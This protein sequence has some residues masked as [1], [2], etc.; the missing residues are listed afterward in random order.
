MIIADRKL[1]QNFFL[2]KD[3]G[4]PSNCLGIY[5]HTKFP[6]PLSMTETAGVQFHHTQKYYLRSRY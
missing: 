3:Q 1:F 6:I 5:Q 4:K 2:A